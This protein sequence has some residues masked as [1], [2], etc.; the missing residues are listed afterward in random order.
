MERRVQ[1]SN[2]AKLPTKFGE[3]RIQS[4]RETK[5]EQSFDH[6][7]VF[8][9]HLSATPLVR[10]H[11]ECLTGDVFGSQKCDC[12]GELELALQRIDASAQTQGGMLIYLR[13]EGR[14]IGLFNKINAYALQD[15]GY[16]TIEANRAIGFK[17]DERDYD[18]VKDIL[19]HYGIKHIHLLT[20]NPQKVQ[21]LSA[22]VKVERCSIIVPSN[23]HNQQYLETKKNRMGHLL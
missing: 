16:D 2:E 8:T 9:S 19:E 20:N 7:V 6:L 14:G 1:V 12:G 18:I 4:F 10:L 15:Q 23:C 21:A 17:D 5:G 3:F 22:F 11:S 13:Q